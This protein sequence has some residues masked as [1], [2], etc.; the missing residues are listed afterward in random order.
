M[1]VVLKLIRRNDFVT[2]GDELSLVSY[3]DG[4]SLP[5]D[6]WQQG[7]DGDDGTVVETLTLICRATSHNDLALKLQALDLKIAQVGMYAREDAELYGV[8][9]A[10]KMD[11]ETGTRYALIRSARRSEAPLW[12]REAMQLG[13]GYHFLVSY[14]L[15]LERMAA[16]E[17]GPSFQVISETAINCVGGT[18]DYGAVTGDLPARIASM[19]FI[20][21]SGVTGPLI[22]F[23]MG[24]RTD[25]FGTRA[26][27]Q[28]YW[29]L[30]KGIAFGPDSEGGTGAENVDAQAK[31]GYRANTT[32]AT[33]A[34][35]VQ[36]VL[37]I[38]ASVTA[39]PL[40]QR[41]RYLVLLRAKLSAAGTVRV[42]LG[43]GLY[44]AG[45]AV[46]P[47]LNTRA[48]VVITSTS[49]QF[50]EMGTVQ[51]PSPGRGFSG[52]QLFD[53][54]AMAIDA[55]RTS[56]SAALHMDCLVLIPIA[57]GSVVVSMVPAAAG[58][59]VYTVTDQGL[60]IFNL[61]DGSTEAFHTHGA[62]PWTAA[63]PKLSG[64]VPVGSGLVVMAGQRDG[65]ST[66]ADTVEIDIEAIKRWNTLRGAE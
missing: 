62:I 11:N 26:N 54:Y 63:E 16:W 8:W 19:E 29:S 35:M 15:S 22:K 17:A 55:E 25:R 43:D 59:G 20:G 36:R 6:G 10:A 13:V 58:E 57:E 38:A 56:G 65:V 7:I 66:L 28:S 49:Y 60:S 45:V 40:D 41:G 39:T 48:R 31:D 42:R 27:F 21:V 2:P 9:L 1:A 4:W 37:V 3:T 44:G 18:S 46:P 5:N 64:G 53:D 23:W 52:A 33:N 24:F 51:I 61:P 50:Y 30:R 32:F 12:T 47:T 14:T 34:T